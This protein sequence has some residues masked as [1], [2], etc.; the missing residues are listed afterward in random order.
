MPITEQVF[1]QTHTLFRSKNPLILL[2]R[3]CWSR[4]VAFVSW[5]VSL[6]EKGIAIFHSFHR[7]SLLFHRHVGIA[8]PPISGVHV[9]S[10]GDL[11]L[12]EKKLIIFRNHFWSNLKGSIESLDALFSGPT[13]QFYLGGREGDRAKN[14]EKKLLYKSPIL[15]EMLGSFGPWRLLIL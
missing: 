2:F 12:H 15:G 13:K 7:W 14:W 6:S 10:R 4:A 3:M 5:R 8:Y 1:S 11:V 9:S